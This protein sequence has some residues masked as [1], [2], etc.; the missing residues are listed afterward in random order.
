MMSGNDELFALL[1]PFFASTNN[2]LN[3]AHEASHYHPLLGCG[4]KKF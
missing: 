3:G 2:D 4:P 1:S